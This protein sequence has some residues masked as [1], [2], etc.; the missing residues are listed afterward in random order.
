MHF[1]P[2]L[3][4]SFEYTVSLFLSIIE[5]AAL[6]ATNDNLSFSNSANFLLILNT[7]LTK[8]NEFCEKKYKIY[9]MYEAKFN[10]LK[11]S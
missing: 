7:Y 9:F 2:S 6:T 8:N 11:K 5:N 10:N 3:K 1:R 4:V